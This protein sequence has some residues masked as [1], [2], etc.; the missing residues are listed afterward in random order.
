MPVEACSATPRGKGCERS[1]PLKSRCRRR[2]A[3]R[4][5][6]C[7]ERVLDSAASV[8]DRSEAV[9]GDPVRREVLED[10]EHHPSDA[11]V[12]AEVVALSERALAGQATA[13]D[14]LVD[15]VEGSELADATR[16]SLGRRRGRSW[17]G[18][19]GRADRRRLPAARS[20]RVASEARSARRGRAPVA[21]S[22]AAHA[23]GTS[24]ACR[25]GRQHRTGDAPAQTGR[26]QV[27]EVVW[28]LRHAVRI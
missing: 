17:P 3:A 13:L 16:S 22:G 15:G 11:L 7:F 8:P 14:R 10:S 19:R 20:A 5:A 1:S 6:Q 9:V 23:S 2:V 21:D 4:L 25:A 18:V 28:A 24:P 27:E 12:L 26:G